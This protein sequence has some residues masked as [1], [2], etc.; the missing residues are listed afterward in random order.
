MNKFMTILVLLLFSHTPSWADA[1]KVDQLIKATDSWNGV[2]LPDYSEKETEVTVLKI[3]I[4]PNTSLPMHIHPVINVAYMLSGELT[5]ISAQGERKIIRKGDPLIELVNQRHYGVNE[6][7][8]PV[9]ILV[10]YI[11][12]EGQPIT[13]KD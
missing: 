6:G 13:V 12:E 1:V 2:S 9:E 11:G 5:V 7:S 3:T 4:E 8:E 10:V